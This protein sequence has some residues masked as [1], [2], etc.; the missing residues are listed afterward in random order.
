[1]SWLFIDT[2]RPDQFRVGHLAPMLSVKTVKGRAHKLMPLVMKLGGAKKIDGICVVQG[3]GSFSAVR[4]GTLVANLLAR[5][6]KKPLVGVSVS[7][8]EDLSILVERLSKKQISSSTY[9]APVYDAEPN[10]TVKV[11]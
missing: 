7:E 6:W 9:V 11:C 2:S 4:T 1:M 3:P 8:A 10:I 5:L